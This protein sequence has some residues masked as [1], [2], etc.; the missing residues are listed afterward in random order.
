M[1][2]YKAKQIFIMKHLHYLMYEI[3]LFRVLKTRYKIYQKKR[4]Q[5]GKTRTEREEREDENARGMT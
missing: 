5:E 3:I 1:S 2:I 4:L